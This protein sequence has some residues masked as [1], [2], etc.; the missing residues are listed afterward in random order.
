M[1]YSRQEA[2]IVFQTKRLL[3]FV[4]IHVETLTYIPA[5]AID[6]CKKKG[7]Q[8]L[9]YMPSTTNVKHAIHCMI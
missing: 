4:R 9:P 6:D 3:V 7:K 5:I 2:S 1:T 8:N